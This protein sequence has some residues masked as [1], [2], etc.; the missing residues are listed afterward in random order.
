MSASERLKAKKKGNI[1]KQ[2]NKVRNISPSYHIKG[3]YVIGTGRRAGSE[4]D[5]EHANWLC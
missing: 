1:A 5:T 4:R 3:C 2:V